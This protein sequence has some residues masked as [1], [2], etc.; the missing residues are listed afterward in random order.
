MTEQDA[1]EQAL[2]KLDA[3]VRD[4]ADAGPLVAVGRPTNRYDGHEKTKSI[5][6]MVYHQRA[7]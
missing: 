4:D 3:M 6:R 1:F 7:S 5:W 2:A